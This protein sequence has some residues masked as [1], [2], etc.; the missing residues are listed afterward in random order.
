MVEIFHFF[1]FASNKDEIAHSSLWM[2]AQS[3]IPISGD[4]SGVEYIELQ[5][6]LRIK[7]RP[8]TNSQA[9]LFENWQIE[10]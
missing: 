9:T 3:A 4:A 7:T 6:N 1:G 2:L 5:P 8:L 10:S